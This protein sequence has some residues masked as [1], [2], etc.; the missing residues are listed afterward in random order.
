VPFW[1]PIGGDYVE[2]V[3]GGDLGLKGITP[4]NETGS[5]TIITAASGRRSNP[6]RSRHLR[7]ASGREVRREVGTNDTRVPL[8]S[9]SGV[10]L[11]SL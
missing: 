8:N 3:H 2:E 4:L 11:R 6:R 7:V 9:R 5:V 10:R 1:F